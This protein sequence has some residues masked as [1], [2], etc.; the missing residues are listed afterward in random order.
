MRHLKD[1][2]LNN[3]KGAFPKLN[4]ITVVVFMEIVEFI[5]G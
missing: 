2:L 4:F 5:V 1:Y 3:L